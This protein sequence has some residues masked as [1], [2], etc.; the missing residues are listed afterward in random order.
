PYADQMGGLEAGTFAFGLNGAGQVVGYYEDTTRT[1]HGFLEIN[2]LYAPLDDPLASKG[3]PA[4]DVEIPSPSAMNA[5]RQAFCT[6]PLRSAG[7]SGLRDRLRRDVA[8]CRGM[9]AFMRHDG[10]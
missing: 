4:C 2:G 8:N 3:T 7:F 6:R 10:A 5:M 1:R 9:R